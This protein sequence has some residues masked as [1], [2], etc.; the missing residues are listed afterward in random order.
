MTCVCVCVMSMCECPF[1]RKKNRMNFPYFNYVYIIIYTKKENGKKN[2]EEEN[3]MSGM[4]SLPP[5]TTLN[6]R[7]ISILKYREYV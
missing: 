2:K 6:S 3:G 5:H 4:K 7:L 1:L